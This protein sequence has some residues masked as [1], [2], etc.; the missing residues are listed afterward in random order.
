MPD[1]S[2]APVRAAPKTTPARLAKGLRAMLP[3]PVTPLLHPPVL[4]TPPQ[5]ME[6]TVALFPCAPTP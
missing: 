5:L 3:G 1:A 2:T 6:T 4:P